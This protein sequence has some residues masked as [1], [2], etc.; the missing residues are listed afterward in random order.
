MTICA[1]WHP[2]FWMGATG[3]M[4]IP[5]PSR[6]TRSPRQHCCTRRVFYGVHTVAVI[7]RPS[8]VLIVHRWH[9][10]V[11]PVR[12]VICLRPLGVALIDGV[13]AAEPVEV[14]AALVADRV[15]VDEPPRPRVVVAV[16]QQV[17]ARPV[18]LVAPLTPEADRAVRVVLPL[19]RRRVAGP[20]PVIGRGR[21]HPHHGAGRAPRIQRHRLDQVALR[22]V[23]VGR[24]GV[25]RVGAAQDRGAA[26]WT[27]GGDA[28]RHPAQDRGVGGG[29]GEREGRPPEHEPRAGFLP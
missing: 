29:V 10:Q 22:V 9:Q 16:P 7:D 13:V 14:D 24:T 4:L 17:Q 27:S 23:G 1:E 20:E 28:G 11:R 6:L 19:R 3:Q 18:P 12:P 8:R 26:P 5:Q 21:V 15:P 2:C 25:G